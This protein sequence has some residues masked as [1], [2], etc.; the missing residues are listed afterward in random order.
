M[1]DD[2]A[3]QCLYPQLAPCVSWPGY[4][5]MMAQHRQDVTVQRFLHAKEV[6]RDQ[7]CTELE[8]M[9]YI[10]TATLV[11][12]PSSSWADI[13][14]WLFT[15]WAQAKGQSEEGLRQAGVL[16]ERDLDQQERQMLAG[17]RCWIFK[18]QIARVKGWLKG[19]KRQPDIED[20]PAQPQLF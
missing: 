12:P 17:L 5:D 14:G 20:K 7:Q 18:Q 11:H 13:Y 16:H 19:E 1:R 10:S 15:R 6:F 2:L 4:E 9:L 8:A 3:V